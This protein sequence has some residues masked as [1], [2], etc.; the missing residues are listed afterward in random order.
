MKTKRIIAMAVTAL[1]ASLCL[2]TGIQAP[3]NAAP[4]YKLLWSQEFND[5]KVTRPS[6][7]V[8]DYDLTD[9]YGWGNG[10]EQYYTNYTSNVKING[11]GQ[12][13]VTALRLSDTNP[14]LD[15]CFTCTYTSGRIKTA[16]LY[17][18]RYGKMSARIKMPTGEGT[19]PAFWMLGDTIINGGTWPEGGEIDIIETRGMAPN[20]AHATVHGPGYFGGNGRGSTFYA[21]NPLSAAYH[22]YGIE[23]T[24]NKIEFKLDGV[25][26]YTLT[27]QSV[28]G[29]RYVYNQEFFLILNLAMGGIFGGDTD[30]DVKKA[31]MMVDW[32]RYYSINGQGK[33]FK[34]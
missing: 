5:K 31:T 30:P 4:K 23:W 25:T 15:R 17:G 26:Y 19:W 14:I 13:E 22:E 34:H 21:P 6:A 3:A 2:G 1:S 29:Y 12:L 16:N 20:V 33:V 9:G 32:I 27:P 7:K 28:S 10:E 8:W 18:F 11:K 24:P